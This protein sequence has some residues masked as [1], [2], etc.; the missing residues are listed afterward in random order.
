ME[1]R[2]LQLGA[3]VRQEVQEEARLPLHPPL[4]RT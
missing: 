4:P 1:D 3:L 2:L